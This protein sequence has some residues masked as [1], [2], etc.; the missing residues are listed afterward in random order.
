MRP[1]EFLSKS[2]GFFKEIQAFLS[3]MI[4]FERINFKSARFWSVFELRIRFPIFA[5]HRDKFTVDIFFFYA[6]FRIEMPDALSVFV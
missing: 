2:N 4:E 6:S 5:A 1:F 3:T